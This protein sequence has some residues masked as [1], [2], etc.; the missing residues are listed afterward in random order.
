MPRPTYRVELVD[1]LIMFINCD[2][3]FCV[4]VVCVVHLCFHVS[5]VF[6][7]SSLCVVHFCLRVPAADLQFD[8]ATNTAS[9]RN[10]GALF[11]FRF[12]AAQ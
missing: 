2:F 5:F 1:V 3:C 6:V 9:D 10:A 12:C 11:R 4:F 8:S 7:R